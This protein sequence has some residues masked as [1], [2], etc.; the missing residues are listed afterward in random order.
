MTDS[1]TTKGSARDVPARI[2]IKPARQCG[3]T[4]AM[5]RIEDLIKAGKTVS[6]AGMTMLTEEA[7]REISNM[8][9]G[10]LFATAAMENGVVGF[11]VIS[12]LKAYTLSTDGTPATGDSPSRD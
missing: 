5:K 3:K 2:F 12:D 4:Q 11:A 1:T 10:R 8:P 6:I 7:V 9:V